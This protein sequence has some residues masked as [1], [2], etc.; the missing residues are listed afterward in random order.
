MTGFSG[1]FAVSA[2]VRFRSIILIFLCFLSM[3]RPHIWINVIHIERELLLRAERTH[4]RSWGFLIWWAIHARTQGQRKHVQRVGGG[5]LAAHK[6]QAGG[7]KV[8]S[9]R[10]GVVLYAD[11]L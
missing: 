1:G 2:L 9:K 6:L 7:G 3:F 8:Q 4:T 10:A 11:G 5:P